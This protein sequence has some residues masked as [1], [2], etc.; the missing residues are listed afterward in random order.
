MLLCR[1]AELQTR[2]QDP[3]GQGW[4]RAK[5]L[6]AAQAVRVRRH[7]G[8]VAKNEIVQ[9]SEAALAE[10]ERKEAQGSQDKVVRGGGVADI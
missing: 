1:R 7:A 4:L 5:W 3:G 6:A 2:E 10:H 8:T 9:N